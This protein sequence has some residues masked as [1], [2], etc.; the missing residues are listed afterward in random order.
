MMIFNMALAKSPMQKSVM[1]QQYAATNA[2]RDDSRHA[3]PAELMSGFHNDKNGVL[4]PGQ[5]V[6]NA[7]ARPQQLY[8]EWD[9]Q[10]VTQFRLDEGDN[11]LN[12][13]M[14]LARSLPIGR[15]I[16][17]NTRSSDAGVFAQ[18]MTGEAVSVYDNV[19][20][21]SDKALVP[22]NQNGFKRNWREGE[23]LSLEAF[24]DATIQQM[25]AVRTH[26]QGIIGSFMDGHLDGNGQFIVEDGVSWQGVRNDSRVDQIDLG[27]GGL[28]IDFTSQAV[29]G[30]DFRN[31]W[32]KLSEARYITNKVTAPA[33][34]F[35]SN[36]IWFNMVRLYSDQYSAGS[37]LDNLR[38]IPGISGIEPSSVLVGNQVLSI[39]LTTTYIQPLVGMGV[40]TIAC[41]R[42]KWNSPFEFE[43]VSAIGWQVKTD[44]ESAG[45]ALQYA[46]A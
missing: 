13:L 17:A 42:P 41:P 27:V 20:Y 3:L 34:Y 14:P 26:R 31:A 33:T 39:P 45:K 38:N 23:Q 25:E 8:Q 12:R 7:G 15:T 40:S 29:S 35:V 5:I 16:L 36:E 22:I 43:V 24:D 11:I 6:G 37:I 4:V 18:S 44:F 46:S 1:A 30:E 2:H 10:T 32:I 28:N 9:T 19:D 21:D